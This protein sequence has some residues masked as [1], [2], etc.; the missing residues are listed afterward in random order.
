MRDGRLSGAEPVARGDLL[1]LLET[2]DGL[3]NIAETVGFVISSQQTEF[4]KVLL[5]AAAA[6]IAPCCALDWIGIKRHPS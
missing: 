4:P 5:P 6:Y 1:G 3:P 2:Y